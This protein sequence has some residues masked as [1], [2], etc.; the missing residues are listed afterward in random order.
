MP[1]KHI[2]ALFEGQELSSDFKEK[3]DSIME[4]ALNERE[5]EIREAIE[6]EQKELFESQIEEKTKELE[7]LSEK[8]VDE[9]VIPTISKYLTAAVN[10][11]LEENE[12][13]L[14]SGVKVELAESFLKGFVGLA[15]S[16]NLTVPE[17]S[18]SIVEKLTKQVDEVKEKLDA[19]TEKN[20][21]LKESLTK[22]TQ[23]IVLD[24]VC[25][26]LTES[27]KEKLAQYSESIGFKNEEQFETALTSL[28]ESYFPSKKTDEKLDEEEGIEDKE[29][30]KKVNEKDDDSSY[31]ANLLKQL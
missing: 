18:D 5:T 27:Q 16:H 25:S 20:I 17:D 30:D 15:E 28:R 3:A 1:N 12:I 23:G 11:W 8:Y 31:Y 26:D 7:E 6:A 14:E 19:V 21:E 4:A 29:S 9:E 22:Q 13:A 24:R 2:Q 10:E